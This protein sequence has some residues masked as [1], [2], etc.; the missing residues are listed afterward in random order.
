MSILSLT[1]SLVHA[2]HLRLEANYHT[3][4]Y[5][6]CKSTT[7]CLNSLKGCSDIDQKVVDGLKAKC[8][9]M[10]YLSGA[11]Y[12]CSFKLREL[13]RPCVVDFYKLSSMTPTRCQ[14]LTNCE[15]CLKSSITSVCGANFWRQYE[16]HWKSL[17]TIWEC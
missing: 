3:G 17:A 14:F 2:D 8:D 16:P 5:Q 13:T 15:Q 12:P 4:I 1:F 6:M 9:Y 11:F 7:T 10:V